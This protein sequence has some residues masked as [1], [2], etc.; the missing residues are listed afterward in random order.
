MGNSFIDTI[1]P[2]VRKYPSKIFNS[3]TI[4]Q[5]CLESHYGQSDLARGAR[6]LFGIKASAPWTGRAFN[7]NS[8]EERDGKKQYE[9]S[10]FRLY[11]TYEASIADHA[12]FFESTPTRIELYAK[13]LNANTP[14]EQANALTGVYAT[15]QTNQRA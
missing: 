8:L 13:A 3:V 6:N 7:K 15:D 11:E 1:A 12:T 14:E 2:L 4:A 10:D 5:A 9:N